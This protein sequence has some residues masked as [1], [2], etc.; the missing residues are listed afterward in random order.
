MSM[1]GESSAP[2]SQTQA[3]QGPSPYVQPYIEENLGRAQALTTQPYQQYS[4]QIVSGASPLQ[5]QAFQQVGALQRPAQFAMGTE[6]AEAGGR[7]MLT[8]PAKALQYGQAGANY[9]E[10]AANLGL[11]GVTAGAQYANMATD[12]ASQQAYMSPYMQNVVD[13]QKK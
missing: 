11:T 5:T 8:T 3:Q 10:A 13:Y 12:P 1:G 4:G 2:S 7:G 6:L 9:G